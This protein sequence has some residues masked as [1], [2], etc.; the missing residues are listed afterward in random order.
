MAE[1]WAVII[2]GEIVAAFETEMEAYEHGQSLKTRYK[3]RLL[4][5]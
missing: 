4:K 3:V 1:K 2:K 5:E